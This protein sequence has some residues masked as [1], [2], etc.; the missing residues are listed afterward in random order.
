MDSNSS[1]QNG[2]QL[3]EQDFQKLTQTI[4]SSIQKITQNG[5]QNRFS[6]IMLFITLI[7]SL[8]ACFAYYSVVYAKDGQPDWDAPRFT[9]FAKTAVS[10][11]LL[12]MFSL[13]MHLTYIV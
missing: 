1:Y 4:A 5:K 7:I 9:G 6:I 8:K 10:I 12:K 11:Y 3:R 13:K 2:S